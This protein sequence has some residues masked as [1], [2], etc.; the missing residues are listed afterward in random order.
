MAKS[1][2]QVAKDHGIDPKEFRRFLRAAPSWNNPGP[3]KRY[4]FEEQ[5]EATAIKG[6]EAWKVSRQPVKRTRETSAVM[7]LP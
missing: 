1:G 4:T 7:T 2:A 3:G 6:Y 5:D